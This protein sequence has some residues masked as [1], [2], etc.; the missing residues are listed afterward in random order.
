MCWPSFRLAF[1]GGC[2]QMLLPQENGNL[3]D[4][5]FRSENDDV[6]HVWSSF[7]CCFMSSLSQ[8]ST[9]PCRW[10]WIHWP[11]GLWVSWSLWVFHW[12]LQEPSLGPAMFQGW[13]QWGKVEGLK[14]NTF[15][16]NMFGLI[17][18]YY[19]TIFAGKKQW[20]YRLSG[21]KHSI[22]LGSNCHRSG[23]F[24]AP[25]FLGDVPGLCHRPDDLGLHR[26]AHGGGSLWGDRDDPVAW[27]NITKN[28]GINSHHKPVCAI[29]IDMYNIY[30]FIRNS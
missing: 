24:W 12:H 19:R 9:R 18:E 3:E 22:C 25:R 2:L 26:F 4:D 1:L 5:F 27:I 21:H 15:S 10:L 17:Q 6:W 20:N 7:C 23:V 13:G 14:Q 28:G 16:F 11:P 8:L 29:D 30:I